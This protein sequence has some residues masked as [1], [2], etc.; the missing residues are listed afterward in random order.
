MESQAWVGTGLG[1]SAPR[2]CRR[3]RG[4]EGPVSLGTRRVLERN[5]A[6]VF[7]EAVRKRNGLQ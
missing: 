1:S 4:R 6:L 3:M 2:G 7:S 5:L